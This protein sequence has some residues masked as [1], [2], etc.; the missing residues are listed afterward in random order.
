M[1]LGKLDRKIDIEQYSL[2]QS[3][4][5]AVSKSWSLLR[6]V[7]AKVDY[8]GGGEPIEARQEQSYNIVEFT[9][10]FCKDLNT[11]NADTNAQQRIKF[12]DQYFDILYVNEIGR[13]TYQ[14]IVAKR[15][16]IYQEQ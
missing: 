7:F 1:N 2:V 11:G 9:I 14:K 4:T 8:K 3:D 5:G 13:R 16:T 15:K 6:S 10:R 12:D